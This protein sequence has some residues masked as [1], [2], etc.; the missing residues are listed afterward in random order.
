MDK[1]VFFIGTENGKL[2]VGK[3]AIAVLQNINVPVS[4]IGITGKYR[5]GKSYLMN[6]LFGESNGFALG[7]TIQSKTKGIWLW[8]RPHPL[9]ANQGLVLL[10]TEGLSDPKKG[11][12]KHDNQIFALAVLLSSCL[13]YNSMGTISDD[14]IRS[15]QYLL[16]NCLRSHFP[17]LYGFITSLTEHIKLQDTANEETGENFD[18]SF[19]VFVWVVRDFGLDL[20]IDD[21]PCTEDEYLKWA[22]QLK[23]GRSQAIRDYNYPR[24]CITSS[25]KDTKC[26]T[27]CRPVEEDSK[28]HTLDT[29]NTEDL[30]PE[31]VQQSKHFKEWILKQKMQMNVGGCIISG[32][33]LLQLAQSYVGAINDGAVPCVQSAVTVMGRNECKQAIKL[34]SAAYER[35]MDDALG[36]ALPVD[37]E[38]LSEKHQSAFDS[39]VKLYHANAML[40]SDGEYSEKLQATLINR[41]RGYTEKNWLASVQKCDLLLKGFEQESLK[42]KL[43]E[44]AFSVHGGYEK[45][46]GEIDTIVMKFKTSKGKGPAAEEVLAKFLADKQE[47]RKVILDGDKAMTEMNMEKATLEEEAKR[48][49]AD[50]AAKSRETEML[51]QQ[52]VDVE[53]SMQTNMDM[54]KGEFEKKLQETEAG[55][56]ALLAKRQAEHEELLKSELKT[57]AQILEKSIKDVKEE[58]NRTKENMEETISTLKTTL[59]KRQSQL[60]EISKQ[61]NE[62]EGTGSRILT[63]MKDN[64]ETLFKMWDTITSLARNESSASGTVPG[65]EATNQQVTKASEHSVGGQFENLLKRMRTTGNSKDQSPPD[66]H[67]PFGSLTASKNARD[68]ENK[69]GTSVGSRSGQPQR[70]VGKDG[71]PPNANFLFGRAGFPQTMPNLRPH[72]SPFDQMRLKATS[73]GFRRSNSGQGNKQK[74]EESHNAAK[75]EETGKETNL[76]SSGTPRKNIQEELD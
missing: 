11:D 74:M 31:F 76:K 3:D 62:A 14:A 10:D 16:H 49:A 51:K 13:V 32:R 25:F 5:T 24:E 22:L 33:R 40:D 72:V 6:L 50:A 47:Q 67:P 45:Y 27:L 1:P 30:K 48:Q 75:F 15:L 4:V 59:E 17:Q 69:K 61:P 63:W 35:E 57:Q 7:S 66:A 56:K 41:F 8:Y 64:P 73:E 23:A 29:L 21:K 58:H 65:S 37:I 42:P 2:E 68:D 70:A 54:L 9:D 60:S 36:E 43:D 34:A 38:G 18:G 52:L 20:E 46:K 26:F 55:Y 39:A 71:Q 44:A 19:P 12:E 53:S 28:L